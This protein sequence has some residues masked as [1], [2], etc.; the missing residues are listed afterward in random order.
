MVL[1]EGIPV[2][3]DIVFWAR[4]GTAGLAEMAK[5]GG[6]RAIL[7]SGSLSE[8][9]TAGSLPSDARVFLALGPALRPGEPN[10]PA[11]LLWDRTTASASLLTEALRTAGHGVSRASLLETLESFHGV[12]TNLPVPISFGPDRRVGAS[13]VRVMT[14]DP[15]NQEFGSISGDGAESNS[16]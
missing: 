7:I 8:V 13:Y 14:F 16:Y 11:R 1:E 3:A 6:E 10:V 4:T 5:S 15:V 9:P 2:G 12:Q